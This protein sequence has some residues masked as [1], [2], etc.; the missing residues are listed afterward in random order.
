MTC[1]FDCTLTGLEKTVR[2]L[3]PIPNFLHVVISCLAR[4][5]IAYIYAE[6]TDER[7]MKCRGD[8]MADCCQNILRIEYV[9]LARCTSE[10]VGARSAATSGLGIF[11]HQ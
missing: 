3:S 8:K 4:C 6:T 7:P 11:E 10:D 2:I 1:R 9:A 5:G